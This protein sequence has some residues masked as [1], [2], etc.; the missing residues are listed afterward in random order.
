MNLVYFN[1]MLI[2][3]NDAVG[4]SGHPCACDPACPL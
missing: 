3:H 2:V 4:G 1:S